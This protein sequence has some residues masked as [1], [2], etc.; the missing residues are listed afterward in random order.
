MMHNV[1]V[2]LTVM[3]WMLV[4]VLLLTTPLFRDLVLVASMNGGWIPAVPSF[5]EL[6]ATSCITLIVP[7]LVLSMLLARWIAPTLHTV[8]LWAILCTLAW[9]CGWAIIAHVILSAT[10]FLAYWI[11]V[12]VIG[13]FE[14]CIFFIRMPQRLAPYLWFRI[15]TLAVLGAVALSYVSLWIV[16]ETYAILVPG[17]AY[18]TI[19]AW[20]VWQLPHAAS[21]P[22]AG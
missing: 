8:L 2:G 11:V 7:M 1:G 18:A 22:S 19:T 13:G 5:V 15:H 10:Y 21:L 17:V 6:F 9:S 14:G 20:Y 3:V 16:P 12:W 4:H